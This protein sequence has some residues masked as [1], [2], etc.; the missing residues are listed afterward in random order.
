MNAA[1]VAAEAPGGVEQ[2]NQGNELDALG[3]RAGD[4]RPLEEVADIGDELPGRG[5]GGGE[6]LAAL[7]GLLEGRPDVVQVCLRFEGE[8]AFT[9]HRG[10]SAPGQEIPDPAPLS[11][12]ACRD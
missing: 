7:A 4:T 10:V 3:D 8:G 11:A 1:T 5:T 2:R 12:P 9:P 6:R